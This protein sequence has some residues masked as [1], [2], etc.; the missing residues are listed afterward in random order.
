MSVQLPPNS[1]GSVVATVTSGGVEYQANVIADPVTPTQRAS[2]LLPGA[3]G[4]LEVAMLNTRAHRADGTKTTYSASAVMVPVTGANTDLIQI[5]GS[6]TKTVRVTKITF[7]ATIATTAE[8]WGIYINK[9]S[10]ANTGGTAVAPT[11]V[12]LDSGD[13]AGT[14]VVSHYTTAPTV[15]AAVGPIM[16]LKYTALI[17]PAQTVQLVLEFGTLGKCPVLRGVAEALCVNVTGVTT[18]HA[19]SVAYTVEW[20]EE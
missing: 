19:A 14:A 18:G 3:S 15:G 13:A 10:A 6:A 1:T 20:T 12:P 16:A 4:L 8:T 11:V 17:A 9:N 5:I 2:V 7:A